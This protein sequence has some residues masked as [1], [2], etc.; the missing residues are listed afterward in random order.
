MKKIAIFIFYIILSIYSL[1]ALLFLFLEAKTL[2]REDVLNKRI[3]LA[4]KKGIKFDTR[5]PGQAFLAF[6][7]TNKDL[8]PQFYYSPIFRFSKIF[9]DARKNNKIIPFRGP[10][11][12]KTLS[13]GEEGKY[14]LDVS[15]KFGF[16]NSNT[17]YEKNINAVVLGDSFAQ[18][19]CQNI[20]NDIPGHLTKKG[21]PTVNFGVV[22]TSVLVAL[23]IMREFGKTISPKNF[24]YLYSEGNDL[25]G[26]NWSK[27]D[28]HLMNYMTDE[29]NINYLNRYDEIKNFLRLT[30][31]ETLS[32]IKSD[33]EKEN[34]NLKGNLETLK[35]KFIDILEL[36]KIKSTIIYRIFDKEYIK[37]DLDLFFLVVKKMD[38]EAKKYNSNFIFVYVPSSFRYFPT[39]PH[40][41]LETKQ[42]IKL[43]SVIL[44]EIR[45]M[46]ISVID[47][48][49]FFHS[50][51]DIEQYYS[52]GYLGHFNSE[53]YKKVSEII[54]MRLKE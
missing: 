31:S 39:F 45:K 4:E 43:K 49:N 53:G 16:K 20:E 18:G 23:G 19:N 48:T 50:V 6:K 22:G 14:H 1:E 12:S 54:S 21:F 3:E 9:I 32:Y 46:N 11:N 30:S 26:L 52:L 37:T 15:D 27:K 10:I 41:A 34:T 2:T 24:I 33:K 29:Y 8:E 36:K 44:K 42:Q 51:Q 25:V 28:E 5:T 7:E 13:C 35:E 38:Q 40:D 17:I 47:L